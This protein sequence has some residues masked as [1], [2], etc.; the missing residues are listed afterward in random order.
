MSKWCATASVIVDWF[1]LPWELWGEIFTHLSLDDLLWPPCNLWRNLLSAR[2][3]RER[4][5]HLFFGW[6]LD[7]PAR[8][9]RGFYND[10]YIG[11]FRERETEDLISSLG[12]QKDA[13]T[14][15]WD[16]YGDRIVFRATAGDTTPII[17]ALYR[18]TRKLDTLSRFNAHKVGNLGRGRK[19]KVYA[20]LYILISR[21]AEEHDILLPYPSY[22]HLLS[23]RTRTDTAQQRVIRERLFC[24]FAF[25]DILS[26]AKAAISVGR[27]VGLFTGEHW[28]PDN[29]KADEFRMLYSKCEPSATLRYLNARGSAQLTLSNALRHCVEYW[30]SQESLS[31]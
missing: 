14:I 29:L 25:T 16:L 31:V 22:D 8:I 6:V 27:E 7:P 1:T 10:R 9:R 23:S 3:E 20:P 4:V 13:L 24:G 5:K 26:L 2:L 30:S 21:S 15:M 19:R 11:I 17:L 12:Q 28:Q 18:E